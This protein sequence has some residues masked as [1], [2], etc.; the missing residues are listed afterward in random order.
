[1]ISREQAQEILKAAKLENPNQ[2]LATRI[3]KLPAK[4]SKITLDYLGMDSSGNDLEISDW[5]KRN[6]F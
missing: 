6:K 3:Q 1:M 2:I 4:L 5:E